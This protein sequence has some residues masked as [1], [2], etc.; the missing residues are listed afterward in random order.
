MY[1]IFVT[2]F[3][4]SPR[5]NTPLLITHV[6]PTVAHNTFFIYKC[7][8]SNPDRVLTTWY[9]GFELGHL[10][11]LTSHFDDVHTSSRHGAICRETQILRVSIHVLKRFYG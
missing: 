9:V 4:V 10:L 2:H 5:Q 1:A 6:R 8:A 7:L 11:L 3:L